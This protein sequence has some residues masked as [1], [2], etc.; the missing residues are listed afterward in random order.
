MACSD[1]DN[2]KL[3]DPIAGLTITINPVVNGEVFS[4]DSTFHL[5][6]TLARFTRVAF[7]VDAINLV[8]LNSIH[9][10]NTATP[11]QNLFDGD[12]SQTFTTNVST[13]DVYQL[14]ELAIGLDSIVNHEDPTIAS[15]PLDQP[16]MHW[17]WN[18]MA[19]YK[20][21]VLEGRFDSDGDGTITDED[22]PFGYHCTNNSLYT[23]LEIGI[24]PFSSSNLNLD[25]DISKLFEGIAIPTEP[26]QHGSGK[27]NQDILANFGIALSLKP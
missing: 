19:G 11:L 1:D 8:N 6:N 3:S 20:F 2:D 26:N 14:L 5:G 22:L 17:G 4:Y 27:T 13:N 9:T 24:N 18:P 25:L 7:Y 12:Q 15:F 16:N 23:P 10:P 21:V